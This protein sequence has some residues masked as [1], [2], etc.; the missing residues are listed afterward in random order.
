M[1]SIFPTTRRRQRQFGLAKLLGFALVLGLGYI[2][3]KEVRALLREPE[4]VLVLGG[5]TAREQF[6]AEFARKH[7]DLPVWISSGSNP[8][9]A[10]WVFREAGIER[11]RLRLDYR[12]VDTLTNFTTLVDEFESQGISSIYLITSDY[13][14]RRAWVIGKI[15]LGSRGIEFKPVEVPS[16]Q[17]AE[18]TDKVVRDAA[19]AVLWVTTGHTGAT[20]GRYFRD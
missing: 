5:S 20:L 8:E 7:P 11:D 17:P 3:L 9:Y 14:M 18:T 13:H 12:A 4:A 15:V 6:A 1:S 19:R 10:E 16:T 2:A